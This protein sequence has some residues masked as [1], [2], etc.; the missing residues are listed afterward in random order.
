MTQGASASSPTQSRVLLVDLNNFA[1]YPSMSIGYIAAVLRSAGASVDVFAPLMVGVRG[2]TRE[3]RPHYFS[4]LAAKLNHRVAT[5]GSDRVRA[6]R[7]RL[8]AG[9]VSD[10]NRH[11]KAVID[12]FREKIARNRPQG[13]MVSTYLMYRQVCEQICAICMQ[14]RIPV[15][16][17]GPYFTQPDVI[18][19]WLRIPGLS[20][21][22]AGE[23]ELQ[24]PSVM[25]TLLR[26]EDCSEHPGVIVMDGP[27]GIKGTPAAP[28]QNLDTVPHPDY[29]DFPWNL[30]PNRIVPVI[31]GRGCG[32]GVCTFCSD[33]TSTAGRTYRSRDTAD[34]MAEIAGH[35]RRYDVSRFVFTDLKLNSNVAMWRAIGSG[36]QSVAPG[37]TWIGAVHVGAEA[38]NGLSRS[39]LQAAADSGCVRLTTGLETGSQRMARLMRKGTRI[40]SISRFLR[41]ATDVGISCRCTMVL[42]YPG[43]TAEDVHLSAEFLERH[44]G[45]IERVSLNRLQVVTGTRLHELL[46]RKPTRFP[47]VQIVSE[48]ASSARVN[49]QY[50]E[51]ASP[52][53]R[54]AVMRLLTAVHHINSKGLSG[55]AREFEGVM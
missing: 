28:L 38:D 6:W 53:H 1:R 20:A 17:G 32:W 34:V 46:R 3:A 40:E 42:G 16:I 50:A 9:R 4:L 21:L 5:S 23:V 35:Y 26:G 29:S 19:D 44:D 49:H 27:G 8:A 14:E 30:Y 18:E 47:G 12:G 22:A 7:N 36:I 37:A 15:L 2:V 54:K 11:A 25:R 43:E 10:I 24:L 31:T 39:E 13:V 33:V 51:T 52:S 48:D 41:D 55:R 45:V